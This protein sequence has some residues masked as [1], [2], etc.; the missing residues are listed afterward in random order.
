MHTIELTCDDMLDSAVR[1][2]WDRLAAEGLPSQARHPHPTNPPP[3]DAGGLRTAAARRA[4]R[5][6]RD[7]R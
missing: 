3:S 1:A 4:G 2:V 7:L 5:V 6:R